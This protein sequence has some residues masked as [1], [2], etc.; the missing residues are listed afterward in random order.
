MSQ[1]ESP[2]AGWHAD[3]GLVLGAKTLDIQ[4]VISSGSPEAFSSFEILQEFK[5]DGTYLLQD[6]VSGTLLST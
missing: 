3:R 2:D 5:L 1:M 6:S 4:A